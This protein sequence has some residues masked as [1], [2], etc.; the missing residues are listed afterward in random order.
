[1]KNLSKCQEM[2]T[3]QQEIYQI[4]HIIKIIIKLLTQIYQQTNTS[5][6]QQINF[7]GKQKKFYNT[8]VSKSNLC[9]YNDA[10]ILVKG[11][12]TININIYMAVILRLNQHLKI[13]HHS[14]NVT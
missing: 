2:M 12:I 5:I 13:M 10:Y 4:F 9:D 6:P 3:I 8:E 7:T 14:L 1:M 11:K